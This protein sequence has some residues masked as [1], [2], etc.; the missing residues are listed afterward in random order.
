MVSKAERLQLVPSL[1]V[2][3]TL[4]AEEIARRILGFGPF[5]SGSWGRVGRDTRTMITAKFDEL[6]G[7][8]ELFRA[9]LAERIGVWLDYTCMPQRPLLPD[10]IPEFQRSLRALDS[11]VASSTV[12]ALRTSDD[13]YPSRGWCAMEFFLGSERSFARG[14]FVDWKRLERRQ[15]VVVPMSP[16]SASTDFAAAQQIMDES[17]GQ[18]LKAFR[19]ACEQWSQIEGPLVQSWTPDAWSAYRSLQGSGFFTSGS[20][21]NPFRRAM[22]AIRGLETFLIDNWLMSERTQTIDLGAEVRR[23]MDGI[24]LH[25]SERGDVVYVALVLACHG[26]IDALRSLLRAALNRYVDRAPSQKLERGPAPPPELTVRLKPP[27]ERLRA[28]FFTVTPSSASTWNSRL[29]LRSGRDSRERVT[30]EQLLA[31]LEATPPKYA[32]V[33]EGQGSLV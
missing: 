30:I 24:G 23:F 3:G 26:W 22:D 27:D 21:P 2:E 1:A 19:D 18:D 25:C 15:E 7:S 17:Y 11:L 4:Q 12:F 16:A 8:G 28:L 31:G 32:F 9:W 14:L 13:D 5:G 20:D 29:S 10:E 33:D 6:R